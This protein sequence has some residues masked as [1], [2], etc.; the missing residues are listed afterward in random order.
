MKKENTIRL[1][2]LLFVLALMSIT[3]NSCQ[4]LSTSWWKQDARIDDFVNLKI[5][6]IILCAPDDE[7]IQEWTPLL[8][9]SDPNKISKIVDALK[10]AR[11][12][13]MACWGNKLKIITTSKKFIMDICS[14]DEMAY[15]NHFE[16]KELLKLL[17]E[18]GLPK[19]K[20][21]VRPTS[22]DISRRVSFGD[23][24]KIIIC[25][26]DYNNVGQW[27]S[28]IEITEPE[29]ISRVVEALKDIRIF[30]CFLKLADRSR[31]IKVVTEDKRFVM[32]FDTNLDEAFGIYSK[33]KEFLQ[34][35]EEYGLPKLA[36]LNVVL[37]FKE[38]SLVI[39]LS[40]PS[41]AIETRQR[42]QELLQRRLKE[43]EPNSN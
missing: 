26:P 31:G 8:T 19:P 29:K 38:R 5:K 27:I 17:K 28:L 36:N 33:A 18:Y 43:K 20:E 12:I 10:K 13:E 7:D 42:L 9:V 3:Q 2:L 21:I 23:P 34:L 11:R 24:N 22:G 15:G 32:D 4:L 6:K 41:K 16:S 1:V 37:V 30:E 40:E 39:F 25:K 14:N 35:L